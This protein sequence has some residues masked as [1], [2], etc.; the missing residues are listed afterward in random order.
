M[1]RSKIRIWCAA[2]LI[3]IAAVVA[4]VSAP[5][6]G[7]RQVI[8][9][10]SP[11]DLD[12]IQTLL[13]AAV[14]DSMHGG[15]YLLNVP[16][17]VSLNSLSGIHGLDKVDAAD[18]GSIS[19]QTPPPASGGMA[20]P[21][22]GGP[23]TWYN[24]PAMQGYVN[25]P[26]VTKISLLQA[27][28]QGKTGSGVRVAVIDTGVDE[29]NPTLKSVLLGGI[30]Y[31]GSSA[32][33]DEL[34]DNAV[35]AQST[36]GI[37]DQSTAGILDQSTAGILDQSTAG[38]LDQSTA[39]I[40][41]GA[42]KLPEF[43]HGTMMAGLIHLVAPHAAIV[44]MKVFDAAGNAT[45][46]NVVRAIRDAVD[47]WHVDV[48]SM[49]FSS[50]SRSSHLEDAIQYAA[51]QGAVVVAAAGNADSNTPTYPAAFDNVIGVSSLDFNN[52]KAPFSNYGPYVGISAPGCYISTY[53][54][55]H[56]AWG[57]GTSGSAAM[58]S[59]VAAL[60]SQ[61][62]GPQGQVENRIEGTADPISVAP[63]YKN[64]LGS[65]LV[66]AYKALTSKHVN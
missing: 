52:Q 25:Q 17:S 44:P 61:G 54:G 57:C 56:W 45:E 2:L 60:V 27:L 12:K 15:Y 9:K 40:L 20:L 18:N 16:S 47:I 23:T 42:V 29:Q 32:V 39:G 19:L 65:G 55:P 37:L 8:I 53:P 34:N 24:T 3:L 62:P 66:D 63:P 22:L 7:W 4:P 31:V 48:I 51:S 5:A 14:L 28:N 30:N 59:G 10:C 46:W 49:S 6:E 11:K 43:G 35:L 58:L 26:L 64:K 38:I 41:D 21:P 36:A 13:G 1:S 33:P 50:T